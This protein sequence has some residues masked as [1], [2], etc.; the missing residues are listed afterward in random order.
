MKRF[1]GPK[2]DA[3]VMGVG[4]QSL[5]TGSSRFTKAE[6]AHCVAERIANRRV[7]DVISM[8]DA[9]AFLDSELEVDETELQE[10]VDVWLLVYDHDAKMVRIL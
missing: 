5:T 1:K 2:F 10:Y 7:V 3:V 6:M 8:D 9:K 4:L